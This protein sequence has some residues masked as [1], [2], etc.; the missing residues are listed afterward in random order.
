MRLW[1][2]GPS[3][4]PGLCH[5]TVTSGSGDLSPTDH[6]RIKLR[7]IWCSTALNSYLDFAH[8]GQLFLIEREVFHPKSCKQTP[9][10]VL[11]I[12][13]LFSRTG[14]RPARTGDQ[15]RAFGL[16]ENSCH[17]IID[18]NSDEDRCRIRTGN[19][20]ENVTRLRMSSPPS[21]AI[22]AAR[23]SAMPTT[24]PLR[25]HHYTQ[26]QSQTKTRSRTD[27]PHQT[28]DRT[29]NFSCGRMKG[30]LAFLGGE[31]SG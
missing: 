11:A 7:R 2:E 21:C 9:E 1:Q 8:V 28:V 17:F 13:G 3:E 5:R 24:H 27:Q 25:D 22:P 23:R 14:Q 6:G 19:A 10:T 29:R 15:S 16:I 12:S 4:Q 31:T 26:S 18:W 20:P 30:K